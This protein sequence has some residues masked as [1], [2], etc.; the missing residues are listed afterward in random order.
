M[1]L[2]NHLDPRDEAE[3]VA[4]NITNLGLVTPVRQCVD[5]R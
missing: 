5:Q 1:H 4:S 2:V 3:S